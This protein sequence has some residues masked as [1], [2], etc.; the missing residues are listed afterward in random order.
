MPTFL[1]KI[2]LYF[3]L[4]WNHLAFWS[5]PTPEENY[6]TRLGTVYFEFGKYGQAIT[7]FKKSEKAHY[8]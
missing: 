3:R 5:F 4:F 7:A 6:Y 1:K 8:S 2:I